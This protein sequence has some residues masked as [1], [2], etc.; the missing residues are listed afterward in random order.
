SLGNF[1]NAYNSLGQYQ[2]AIDFHQQSLEIFREI[3][4]RGGEA[5]SLGNLGNAY[6]SLGQY[7][8]AIDF[9]QQSLDIE[10]EIGDR[11]GEANSWYNYGDTLAKLGKKSQAKAAYVKAQEFFQ[12]IGHQEYSQIANKAIEDLSQPNNPFSIF[13]KAC[14]KQISRF[15]SWL[16]HVFYS[17]FRR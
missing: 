14:L 3:G 4:N 8:Q 2:Q 12:A 1:G 17:L 16:Q 7:Q 13:I 10:R 9:Y 15:L 6:Q 5:N 11:R